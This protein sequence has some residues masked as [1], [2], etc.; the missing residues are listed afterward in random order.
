ML[1]PIYSPGAIEEFVDL[2]V[3]TAALWPGIP[4]IPTMSTGATDS[5]FLRNAGIPAYGV[6]GLFLGPDDSRSHGLNER[7]PVAS[8]WGGQEFLYRLVKTLGGGR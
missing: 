2:V 6:S 5:R 3:P 4:V 1:S 7:M 8:L